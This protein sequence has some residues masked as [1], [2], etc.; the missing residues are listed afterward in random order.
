MPFFI[1]ADITEACETQ[2]SNGALESLSQKDS[3][4]KYEE[5][6]SA[7]S[8]RE[9]TWWETKHI[10]GIKE[11]HEDLFIIISIILE[12]KHYLAD[13]VPPGSAWYTR[14]HCNLLTCSREKLS[15]KIQLLRSFSS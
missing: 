2:F 5:P 9:T 10:G 3:Q 4:G 7:V 8:S 12:A 13:N 15:G 11:L 1:Y 14:R 6:N